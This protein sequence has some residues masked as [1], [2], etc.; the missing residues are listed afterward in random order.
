M[1]KDLEEVSPFAREVI[2]PI[3][4]TS[5]RPVTERLSLLLPSSARI[6][7]GCSCDQLS[8]WERY[9]FTVFR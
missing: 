1:K 9:G 4:S 5:I 2:S 3:G 8:Q 7:V 6:V